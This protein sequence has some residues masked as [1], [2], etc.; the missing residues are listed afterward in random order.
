MRTRG[1]HLSTRDEQMNKDLYFAPYQTTSQLALGHN[2]NTEE[3]CKRQLYRLARKE[4]I[5]P[6]TP[7]PGFTIWKLTNWAWARQAEAV[8]RRGERNR[9]WPDP[10][11]VLHFVDANDIYV[12]ASPNLDGKLGKYPEWEW[13]AEHRAY[14]KYTTR[15]GTRKHQPDA[16]IRFG[17]KVYFMERQTSRARKTEEISRSAASDTGRTWTTSGSPT[18]RSRWCSPA[19]PGAT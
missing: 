7:M 1:F 16:E 2:F 11:R 9:G 13:V 6:Y 10:E 18:R 5:E 17:G 19:I 15:R 8:G 4:V 12:R 14:R 3:A